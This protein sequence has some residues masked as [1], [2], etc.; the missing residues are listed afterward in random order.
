ML[1]YLRM[2]YP[3]AF[4]QRRDLLAVLSQA[5]PDQ[6]K[7][8]TSKRVSD[9]EHLEDGV[10]VRC[11]DGSEYFGDIVVGADGVRSTVRT[12]MQQHIEKISPGATEKDQKGLSAEY[13]CIFGISNA[14]KGD[15]TLGDSHRSYSK[16]HSTLAFIGREGK[17]FW[18]LFSKLEKRFYGKDIP[19]Y[20]Q[21][22]MDEQIKSF[23][24]IH[25]TADITFDRVW[26]KRTFANM[27]CVEEMQ[28]E[29]WTA[30]RFVCIGDS[31]HKVSSD[32]MPPAP[33]RC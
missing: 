23:F 5:Q 33:P 8:L 10:K 31:A 6:S 15:T 2:G 32:V 4:M 9:I 20:D 27:L 30:D 13:N 19:R 29:H 11:Q 14:V 24:D 17:L 16:D 7:I 18:F 1:T 21:A 3:L 25:M 26:E 12:L 22:D 28:L